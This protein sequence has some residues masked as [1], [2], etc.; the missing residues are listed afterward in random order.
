MIYLAGCCWQARA[1]GGHEVV[2]GRAAVRGSVRAG[3]CLL[4]LKSKSTGFPMLLLWDFVYRMFALYTMLIAVKCR[5]ACL[6]TGLAVDKPGS[7][8][9]TGVITVRPAAVGLL[10]RAWFVL[11][12]RGCCASCKPSFLLLCQYLWCGFLLRFCARCREPWD[13]KRSWWWGGVLCGRLTFLSLCAN[14][15]LTIFAASRGI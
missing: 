11:L 14:I 7:D 1:G 12:V 10:V 2:M 13:D 8:C 3:W 4:S 15:A 9:L 6:A 5:T